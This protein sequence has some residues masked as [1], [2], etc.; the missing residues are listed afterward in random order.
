M[1]NSYKA[2]FYVL[3]GKV[4]R[5]ALL[6]ALAASVCRAQPDIDS[7]AKLAA[8]MK[9]DTAR[10]K[11]LSI[12][13]ETAPEGVWQEYNAKMGA[14]AKKFIGS[15]D[16]QSDYKG[17]FYYA[18][19][20]GN[21]G[22]DEENKGRSDSALAYYF[23]SLRIREEIRDEAG[24]S[25]CYNNI[26]L[27][28]HHK[29]DIKSALDYY[30]KA[31][32]IQERIN[33]KLG[34]GYSLSNIAYLLYNQGESDQA[35]RYFKQSLAVRTEIGDLG[36]LAFSLLN[37]GYTYTQKGELDS[38]E[39]YFN[40][41]LA[42]REKIGDK[43]GV[44]YALNNLAGLYQQRKEYK[45]AIDYYKRGMAVQM[46]VG[47]E[48]GL[49]GNYNGLAGLFI[50]TQEFSKAIAYAQKTMEIGKRL[51]YPGD[52]KNAALTLKHAYQQSGRYKDALEMGE[53]YIKMRDSLMN[54]DL[55]RDNLKKQMAFEYEK[56]EAE[57]K[58]RAEAEKE[59]IHLVAA[60]EKRRQTTIIWS[61]SIVLVLVIALALI[62]FKSLQ[63]NR[64][65]NRIISEQ[66][67]MVEQ[68]QKEVLDSI[69]YARRIQQ[70]LMPNEK[71]LIRV[72][73]GSRPDA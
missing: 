10:L 69:H 13:A 40:K 44:G 51:G 58:A 3:Q 41:A 46:A 50:Q 73:N 18:G 14:L 29:G 6:I 71:Y 19:Y 39:A 32:K 67:S 16:K 9:D 63:E 30:H 52:I 60:G 11:I 5:I 72:L 2:L 37:L 24:I 17:K 57:V 61:V 33:D 8:G 25:N 64:K 27:A 20:L 12:L 68:K 23:Q 38:A 62:I 31:L 47:D 56:K 28:L 66:K 65:M 4:R 59:K 15:A 49:A 7:L 35:I 55:R 45:K 26:G 53:L 36:G 1:K 70:S 21:A 34:K 42:I 22:Y 48:A 54:E 43:I